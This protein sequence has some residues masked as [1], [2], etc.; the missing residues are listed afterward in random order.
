MGDIW[1]R[2]PANPPHRVVTIF[3]RL[4]RLRPLTSHPGLCQF[5]FRIV[6]N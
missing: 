2:G 5:L 4:Y 3:T 1:L 6:L